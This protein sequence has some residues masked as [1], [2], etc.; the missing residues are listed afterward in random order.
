MRQINISILKRQSSEL[1]KYHS[2]SSYS[3]STLCWESSPAAK[4]SRWFPEEVSQINAVTRVGPHTCR[5]AFSSL[6]S[7]RSDSYKCVT[8]TKTCCA[9]FADQTFFFSCFESLSFYQT[10]SQV[11]A[12]T[13]LVRIN[14]C[15]LPYAAAWSPPSS[16]GPDGICS[17]AT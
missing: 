17:K 1:H 3:S 8:K 15:V 12:C 6:R 14:A 13:C 4:W 2:S 10:W 7:S 11:W 5:R 16:R 9:V